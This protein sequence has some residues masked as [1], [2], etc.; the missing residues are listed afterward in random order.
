MAN[1]PR[2]FLNAITGILSAYRE[3][4]PGDEKGREAIA[5]QIAES[6]LPQFHKEAMTVGLLTK[7]DGETLLALSVLRQ[8]EQMRHTEALFNIERRILEAR[9]GWIEKQ[10]PG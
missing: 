5:K 8:Q 1:S 2:D 4:K 7:H 6:N 10:T 9:M 3:L